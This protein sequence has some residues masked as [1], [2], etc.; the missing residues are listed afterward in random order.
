MP[1]VM[2][3]G[4]SRGIGRELA[5]QYA[6][7]RWEVV[8]TCRDPE[9]AGMPDALPL[10]V[11]REAEIRALSNAL[12]GTAI[13]VLIN[14]AGIIGQRNATLG[15][16]D[17]EAWEEAFRVNTLAP[18]MIAEALVENV[19]ASNRKAMVFISSIMGSIAN[20]GAGHYAYRSSKA[21]LNSAMVSLSGELEPRG[22]ACV[23]IHPGWVRTDMG[24]RS[25]AVSVADSARGI[26]K[27]V[28]G[29]N[30]RDNGRFYD[31]TGRELP[32]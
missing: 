19:A 18:I 8:A 22:I 2:I 31:Y 3:T 32:W 17:Y 16:I 7:D 11:T 23:S 15:A 27:I 12:K 5:N 26:R 14:N 30:R 21:A 10:D 9:A 6:G 28:A 24:G 29:L 13:D 1:T 4:A 25:A 20:H